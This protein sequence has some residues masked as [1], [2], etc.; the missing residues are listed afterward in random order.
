VFLT[1][2]MSSVNN[3]VCCFKSETQKG[4]KMNEH[5]KTLI[6]SGLVTVGGLLLCIFC[7]G[8]FFRGFIGFWSLV[9]GPMV[10]FCELIIGK[11]LSVR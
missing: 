9:I 10:F 7:E 6:F 2:L 3:R 1:A 8:T 4:G 11:S 5:N